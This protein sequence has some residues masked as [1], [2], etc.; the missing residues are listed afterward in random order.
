MASQVITS[1]LRMAVFYEGRERCMAVVLPSF[2][3]T[4]SSSG[5]NTNSCFVTFVSCWGSISLFF[6]EY[7]IVD[8]Y[9]L[10]FEFQVIGWHSQSV[11][12]PTLLGFAKQQTN[13]NRFNK[14]WCEI[15]SNSEKPVV[16][17]DI[18]ILSCWGWAQLVSESWGTA[19]PPCIVRLYVTEIPLG[20]KCSLCFPPL[21]PPPHPKLCAL[22]QPGGSGIFFFTPMY[23][24]FA[25]PWPLGPSV[26]RGGD[27]F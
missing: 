8:V 12:Q 7:H 20:L 3:L 27:F 18:L 21:P 22:C 10:A 9:S 15:I 14:V 11:E 24:P 25:E 23:Y 17:D 1:V 5:N 13:G 16:C 19:R 26:L 2:I 6:K 4:H